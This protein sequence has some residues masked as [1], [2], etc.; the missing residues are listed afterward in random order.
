LRTNAENGVQMHFQSN[1]KTYVSLAAMIAVGQLAAAQDTQ[2]VSD[3]SDT[4]VEESELVVSPIIVTARKR[5]ESILET[6]VTVK[7]FDAAALESLGVSTFEDLAN[8]TPG[9][10]INSA[11]NGRSDRSFQSVIIRGFTPALSTQQTASIFIDGVPV[12]SATAIQNIGDP[13]RVEVLKGPQ[14]AYFGRQ[15][16]AGAV[17]FVTQAAPDEFSGTVKGAVGSYKNREASIQV[18]GPIFGD[19]LGFT[20]GVRHWSRDG[21]YDNAGLPSQ[22][23]GDQ[24]TN[25]ANF[26]LEFDPVSDFS[27]EVVGL[28]S[29]NDDG[30]NAT[31]LISAYSVFDSDGREV[32]AGQS[33]CEINGNPYFCGELP[34]LSATQPSMNASDDEFILNFLA[35]PTGRLIDPEDGTDGFGLKSRFYHIHMAADW[36]LSD[37]LTLSSLTGYNDEIK[38]QISD[39]KVYYNDSLPN[40]FG[41]PEYFSYP[42]LVEY[43]QEDYSQEFRLDY[44][45]GGPLRLMVGASYLYSFFQSGGGGSPGNLGVTVFPTVSGSTDSD[46]Y[47][48]FFSIGYDV[49]DKLSVSFDGRYQIDEVGAYARPGGQTLWSD[50]FAPAGFY[51]EDEKLLG[52][53]YRNFMPRAIAN[54]QITP[55]MMAYASYSKGVNPG[56]FNVVFLSQPEAT[57]QVAADAGLQIGVEPEELDN[58]EIGLKGRTLGGAMTYS[59]AA[60]HGIW[61]KQLNVQQLNLTDPDTGVP[62][63]IR[64]NVNGGKVDVT[65]LEADVTYLATERL[66]LS[67]SGALNDTSVAEY[68]S[69]TVTTLTGISDFS[70]KESA[71]TSKYS[72]VLSSE[73]R[74]PVGNNGFDAFVRADYMYR[75]GVYTNVSNITKTPDFNQVNLR[76]GLDSDALS[77]ELYVT[78]LLDDDAYT[79]AYDFFTINPSFSYFGINSAVVVGLRE[80]RTVGVRLKH[81]F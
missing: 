53:T 49:T 11:S 46:T 5:E 48:A 4:A 42:Y 21:S 47:G 76:A 65:G 25:S 15:T 79:T 54:Y 57:Q 77:V 18:G 70:G 55:D 61:D 17:N 60:Y 59:I 8:L 73:Y 80:K 3:A 41:G 81:N 44:D 78:N 37:S 33:N 71:Y 72:F 35:S 20:A 30:P 22:S 36:R 1:L 40:F 6:P 56:S 31:G 52:E 63:T 62:V 28:W 74:A 10:N 39:L 51:A 43:H 26:K 50:A 9:M 69:P 14:S 75:D 7:A 29:E 66:T 2:P 13:E 58:F 45:D 34:G 16:F 12:S 64:A 24:S 38:S 68:S 19:V 67:A 32:V 27:V 23:L